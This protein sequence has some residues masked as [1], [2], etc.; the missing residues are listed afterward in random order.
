MGVDDG[1]A[2]ETSRWLSSKGQRCALS[3]TGVVFFKRP[4]A[5]FL[6]IKPG[7][8]FLSNRSIYLSLQFTFQTGQY[9]CLDSLPFKHV[10]IPV[11]TVYLSNRSIYLS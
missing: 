11:L 5:L 10:S 6:H 1:G 4:L 7:R 9:T 2:G 8:G 3:S